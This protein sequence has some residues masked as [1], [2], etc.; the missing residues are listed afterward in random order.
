LA[1]LQNS[2]IARSAKTIAI[3]ALA[4]CAGGRSGGDRSLDGA[5]REDP[6]GAPDA[7]RNTPGALMAA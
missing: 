6:V 3:C 1:Q 2:L 7:L 4:A 5:E